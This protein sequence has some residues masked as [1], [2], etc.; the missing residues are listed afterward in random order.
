VTEWPLIVFTM[1]LQMGCGLC[2]A[3][4]LSDMVS[5]R[6]NDAA[7]RPLGAAIFPLTALGL[8]GSL[9]HLGRPFSALRSLSNLGSSRLSLEILLSVIFALAAFFCSY[10]WRKRV[11]QARLAVGI[12]TTIAGLAAV[13]SSFSIYMIPSQPAWNSGWLPMSFLGTLLLF[14]GAVPASLIELKDRCL[15]RTLLTLALA[16]AMAL[17]GSVAWMFSALSRTVNDDFLNARLQAGLH[18]LTSS[19]SVWFACYLFL[20][21]LMPF[22]FALRLWPRANSGAE[23]FSR[24]TVVA[25]AVLGGAIIGRFLMYAVGTAIP[26]F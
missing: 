24:K 9:F 2:L 15:L 22:A 23:S 26:S 18:L 13:A 5:T 16:G 20:A 11:R 6:A 14:A 17:L 21:I 7:M 4:T 3:A 10:L 12:V 25:L 1:A 19:Y 8:L